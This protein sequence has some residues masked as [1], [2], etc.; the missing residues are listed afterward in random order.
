MSCARN[1][2]TLVQRARS[3]LPFLGRPAL[4]EV[5]ILDALILHRHEIRRVPRKRSVRPVSTS[6][7][8]LSTGRS[9]ITGRL[10]S[11]QKRIAGL[12][13]WKASALPKRIGR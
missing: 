9:R 6:P 12:A 7:A 3:P 1:Y 13:F 5:E 10:P 11:F 4:R 8:P 2:K